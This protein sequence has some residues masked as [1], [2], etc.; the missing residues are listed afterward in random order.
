MSEPKAFNKEKFL[1]FLLSGI[2]I[3]Q[4]ALLAFGLGFCARNGGLKTCPAIG[5]R[6]ETTFNVM[7]ATTLA[8][9]T[10]GAVAAGVS[11]RSDPDPNPSWDDRK[12]V[13]KD[14]PKDP[15]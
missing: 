13:Q 4:A 7:I 11:K 14:P 2:F 10:G 3:F 1:L 6:Y 9:L 15:K 12:R 5:D 8:L